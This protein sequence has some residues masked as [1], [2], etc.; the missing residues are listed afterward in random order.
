[1]EKENESSYARRALGNKKWCCRQK[2]VGETLTP[3][4]ERKIMGR[5]KQRIID[6]G[7]IIKSVIVSQE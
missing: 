3:N 4:T 5:L 7:V 2:E 6:C 1:M